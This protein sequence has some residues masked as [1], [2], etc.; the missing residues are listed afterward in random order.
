MQWQPRMLSLKISFLLLEAGNDIAP[1]LFAQQ[2]MA[3][4]NVWVPVQTQVPGNDAFFIGNGSPYLLQVQRHIARIP[5]EPNLLWR[6]SSGTQG[7]RRLLRCRHAVLSN[8]IPAA[9]T[10]T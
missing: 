8:D 1:L 7:T 6:C 2:P 10:G 5:G 3:W 4:R 9:S